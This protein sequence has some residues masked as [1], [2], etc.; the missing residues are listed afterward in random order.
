MEEL[1][2]TGLGIYLLTRW[3]KKENNPFNV[4]N[5]PPLDRKG[6]EMDRRD[7]E[8]YEQIACPWYWYPWK[9]PAVFN[10]VPLSP[11]SRQRWLD[12]CELWLEI[13][14][15]GAE[16]DFAEYSINNGDVRS[17][18][19]AQV[20]NDI[21]NKKNKQAF[22][23]SET[24]RLANVQM[25]TEDLYKKSLANRFSEDEIKAFYQT[26]KDQIQDHIWPK[27]ETNVVPIVSPGGGRPGDTISIEPGP[28][29]PGS[30]IQMAS[31]Y[32]RA[33]LNKN[34]E[35]YKQPWYKAD[36]KRYA[37][38]PGKRISSTGNTYY[39]Y[40]INRSDQPGRKI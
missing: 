30:D 21:K 18:Q 8:D 22:L 25:R 26:R 3:G 27:N 34:P 7:I 39:E 40:R 12:M 32:D 13:R 14:K 28:T 19:V 1:L 37:A 38:E 11:G 17:R 36:A 9:R 6:N 33:R 16:I 15:L 4:G 31:K 24:K 29:D 5:V 2:L 20:K 23:L 35:N 10:K